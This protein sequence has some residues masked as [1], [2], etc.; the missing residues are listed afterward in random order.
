M[1]K[2]IP[3]LKSNKALENVLER[4]H[5][6][7][8]TGKLYEKYQRKKIRLMA[9]LIVIGLVSALGIHL[10]SQ[11][12]TR[13]AEGAQLIR[14][15][16]GA[17]DYKLT[18]LAEAQDWSWEIPFTVEERAFTK[19][20]IEALKSQLCAQLPELIK[21]K[22][23]DLYHVEEDLNLVTKVQGYPFTLTWNSLNK[24]RVRTDGSINREGVTQEGE[25][26]TLQVTVGIGTPK[27]KEI[28]EYR[29][30]ILSEV[31]NDEEAFFRMLSE[32]LSEENAQKAEESQILLPEE[33]NG[34]TVFWKEKREN[35]SIFVF[36]LFLI[37]SVFAGKGMD[38]DLK[39]SLQKRNKQLAE[40]YADFVNKLR[41][42]LSA[43]LTVRNAF[44][45]MT[46]EYGEMLKKERKNYLY[47]EMK[48]NCF[49]LEN[50]MAE[51]QVY[52]DFG[53]RC[54]EM[55]YRR[56]C[57]LL[58]VHLKQGN[59]QILML[60]TQEADSAREDRKNLARKTGEEAST[61]LLFPMMLML[62]VIMLLI[63]LPAYLDF[64]AI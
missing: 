10:S 36:L 37:S 5:P 13:L 57:Y 14:N 15:E 50:G 1:K 11:M 21:G 48:I 53:L 56:L 8:N 62:I 6:N 43:G 17:G 35:N 52:L 59:D 2:K 20:E 38:H 39:K 61:K 44:I 42:Y 58:G 55:K 49:Q 25:W 30:C 9:G 26:V 32:R 45:R 31:L 54:G 16:W 18:L 63:L 28:F 29:V 46:T 64:S 22:N 34:T 7:E 41:L 3:A 40:E 51:E 47:E 4:L 27:E 33:I 12:E 60:L 23:V 24:D 19:E